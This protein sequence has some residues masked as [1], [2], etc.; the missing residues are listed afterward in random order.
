MTKPIILV[1]NITSL[2]EARYCAGMLVDFISFEFN[3]ESEN[4]IESERFKEI[5]TWLSGIKVLGSF[6][7][8]NIDDLI[9]ICN[10]HK[11]D[12][13]IL[14]KIQYLSLTEGLNCE[15]KI[16]ETQE[17]E[18]QI[19][20]LKKLDFILLNNSFENNQNIEAYNIPVLV[21]YEFENVK[22]DLAEIVGFGFL[23]SKEI[24]TGINQYDELM[25]ALDY[26]EE[27]YN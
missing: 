26:I 17:N 23:G 9:E 18:P 24:Q 25:D 14:D 27:K 15:V 22:K 12:G 21:G 20:D 8:G 5:K 11:I 1:K 6:S 4:Y 10:Q 7:Q 2:S 16:L 13:V 19:Q 3:P